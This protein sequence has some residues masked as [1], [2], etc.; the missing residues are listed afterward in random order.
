MLSTHHP[1]KPPYLLTLSMHPNNTI[2]Q[3]TLSLHPINT[4][5]HPDSNMVALAAT[6]AAGAGAAA[7]AAAAA[8]GALAVTAVAG[9]GD[10]GNLLG[11]DLSDADEKVRPL[12]L[13]LSKL[14]KD[15]VAII[16]GCVVRRDLAPVDAAIELC[17]RE[18]LKILPVVR[19][20]ITPN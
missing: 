2:F 9:T 5:Y 19:C 17:G 14:P 4:P 3:H 11:R 7:A 20:L 1:F 10:V 6:T 18:I 8:E 12:L 15:I 16:L 13:E